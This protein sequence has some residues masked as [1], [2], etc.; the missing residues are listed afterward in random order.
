MLTGTSS[1]LEREPS[2]LVGSANVPRIDLRG[3]PIVLYEVSLGKLTLLLREST[4]PLLPPLPSPHPC[5]VPSSLSPPLPFPPLPLVS[6]LYK[7][8]LLLLAIAID[9]CCWLL[10]LAVAI[11]YCSCPLLLS[12]VI[13]LCYWLLPLAIAIG[14]Q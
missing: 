5:S 4:I 11:G 10:S 13:G 1:C 8:L 6:A 2:Y 14:H 9:Y 3:P 7:R 12:V